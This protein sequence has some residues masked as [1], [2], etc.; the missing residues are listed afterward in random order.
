MYIYIYIYN[1]HYTGT[2]WNERRLTTIEIYVNKWDRPIENIYYILLSA[3][4]SC[5]RRCLVFL[6][7]SSVLL[8][9]F[10]CFFLFVSRF[11]CR[12]VK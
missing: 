6:V 7:V 12:F 8:V 4:A 5:Q 10:S 9:F 11:Y 3:V 1:I 2:M